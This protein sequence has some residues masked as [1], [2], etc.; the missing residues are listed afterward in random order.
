MPTRPESLTTHLNF[1]RSKS[2]LELA[3]R[4]AIQKLEGTHDA[5]LD[6]YADPST[7]R[8][9]AMVEEIRKEFNINSVRYQTL[10]DL[11]EAIG[12]PREQLCTYCWNGRE[13]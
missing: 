4:R 10:D 13:D 3:A 7:E 2:L 12:L 9:A 6:E 11:I 1:S 5:H 8:Y